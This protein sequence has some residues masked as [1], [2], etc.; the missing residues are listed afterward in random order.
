M[1]G[2]ERVWFLYCFCLVMS[3]SLRPHGLYHTSLPCPSPFPRVC[4]SSCPLNRWCYPTISSSVVL[5]SSCLQSFPAEGS[6]P[7]NQP[8][9][10]S[11][12]FS[13]SPSIVYSTLIS[14]RL[15]GL[16][17]LLSKGLSRVFSSITVQKHQFFDLCLLYSPAPTTLHDYWKDHSLD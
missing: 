11:F 13:I 14:L 16:I 9:Y 1:R 2:Q 7:M 8:K 12:S 17:T 6:F 3:D 4:W 15:T 10:W 5:F